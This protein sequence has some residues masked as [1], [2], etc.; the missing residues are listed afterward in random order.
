VAQLGV[1]LPACARQLLILIDLNMHTCT[2]MRVYLFAHWQE[3]YKPLEKMTLWQDQP[4]KPD[5]VSGQVRSMQEK[6]RLA[7]STS[8]LKG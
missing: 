2:P 1:L 5:E 6:V 8:N 7:R 4:L 3:P